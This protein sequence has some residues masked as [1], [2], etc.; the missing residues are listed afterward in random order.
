[1]FTLNSE[2]SSSYYNIPVI[3]TDIHT[4][5]IPWLLEYSADGYNF[6]VT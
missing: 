2:D 5:D 3:N 1:M 4:L 6:R